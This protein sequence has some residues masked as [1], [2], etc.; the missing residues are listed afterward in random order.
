MGPPP[1]APIAQPMESSRWC[2]IASRAAAERSSNR[3]SIT[4]RAICSV[5]V[6]G[7]ADKQRQ[8]LP[9]CNWPAA[10]LSAGKSRACLSI[11]E[12]RQGAAG[13]AEAFGVEVD[14][15]PFFIAAG[16]VVEAECRQKSV[17]APDHHDAGPHRVAGAEIVAL[18]QRQT[19]LVRQLI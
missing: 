6:I 3:R 11:E 4:N 18:G 8:P 15:E 16:V 10:N 7:M 19:V 2:L 13:G 9:L 5:W 14:A 17:E 12:T 1:N